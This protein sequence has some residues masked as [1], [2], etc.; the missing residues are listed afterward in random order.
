MTPNQET[1]ISQYDVVV[2][3]GGPAGIGA[4]TASARNG[5]RTLLVE[6]LSHVGGVATGAF[7]YHWMDTPG[8][9]IFGDLVK[10]LQEADAAH[11]Y[12]DPESHH[13]PGR[14][15]FSSETLKVVALKML[16][17]AGAEI[18]FCTT[19]ESAWMEDNRARGVWVVNKGGRSRIDAQVVIDC[20]ADGDLAASA[21]ADFLK[22]DPDDARLQHVNFKYQLDRVDW[23][24]FRKRG[25]APEE[26]VR[27]V[28]EARAEGALHPPTGV[29]RPPASLF[30]Y[31]KAEGEWA[32]S[33]WE[34]EG[35]D[36]SDPLSV[37]NT[38]VECQLAAFEVVQFCRCHLPGFEKC[39]ISRLPDVLG[40]RES[41]RIIGDYVLTGDD[42]LSARKFDDGIA[43]ACFFIDFH[44]SPPGRTIPYSPEFKK[45]NR[46]PAGDW[47][48][49]P[50]RAL[51][52]KGIEGMLVAGRCISSER[53]A[54]AS[55]RVMPTCMF[56]GAAA[57]TAA[58]IAARQGILPREAE[59]G[60]LV[61]AALLG[62][63]GPNA[64]T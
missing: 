39:R 40:T 12:Y 16:R 24:E 31:H 44:D 11:W 5:A 50:Y 13:K 43:T 8:G 46:P 18:L 63:T 53:E 19:V 23:N 52:P 41:R 28:E 33:K 20:T 34:I 25:P 58:S 10:R 62:L 61:R 56:T 7:I 38:L 22:G 15:E 51:V 2:C 64:E 60:R 30:P 45:A 21:G 37:S 6:R 35:V 36:P 27:L 9:P 14:V 54:Q 29:F 42:V 1:E 26:C 32:L 48:E 17:D 55:L 47:Y 59:V 4:A 57:G 49:I 3:G